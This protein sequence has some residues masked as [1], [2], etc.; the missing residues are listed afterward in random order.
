MLNVRL[1]FRFHVAGSGLS[2]RAFR[3]R[4]PAVSHSPSPRKHEM[5][6]GSTPMREIGHFI[7]AK[8]GAG[9]SIDLYSVR[10]PLGV[11][12]GITPFNF[13]AM[14]PLWKCAPA[15]ACGNSFI[16]KPSERDPSVPIRIAELFVK[17]GLP[18]GVL[19]VVNGDKEAVEGFQDEEIGRA[20]V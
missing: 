4:L 2:V 8:Q 13:P 7:G 12:A 18:E 19:N 1:Q 9:T 15:I 11:V 16:L 20:H 10:Q 3:Q 17:A 5:A 14:I 6:V